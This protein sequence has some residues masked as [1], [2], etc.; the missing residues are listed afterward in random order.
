MARSTSVMLKLASTS[1][2]RS[3]EAGELLARGVAIAGH[4]GLYGVVDHRAVRQRERIATGRHH[5]AREQ[6]QPPRLLRVRAGDR[7]PLLE[8]VLGELAA[9]PG[10]VQLRQG[11]RVL[12]DDRWH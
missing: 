9:A 11:R 4:R 6:V 3:P 8:L 7:V 2:T 5:A 1:I 10:Q 12:R